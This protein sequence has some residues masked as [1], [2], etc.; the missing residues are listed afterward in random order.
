MTFNSNPLDGFKIDPNSISYV[1]TNIQRPECILAARDGSLWVT[2]PRGGVLKIGL[3]GSQTLIAPKAHDENTAHIDPVDWQNRYRVLDAVDNDGTSGSKSRGKGAAGGSLPNGIA[4]AP[5]G[6]IY[7][8]NVG[9]GRLE[10]LTRSGE[11]TVLLD[12][13]DGQ[14]IGQLNFV[15][16]D[17]KDRLWLTIPTREKEVSKCLRPDFTGGRIALYE[18]GKARIVA[19]GIHYTNEIRFDSKEE[20]LYISET[21]G[22]CVSRMRV[23][24]NGDLRNYQVFGPRDHGALIDGITFDSYGNLWG[25][26]VFTDQIFIITPEGDLR[27]L[28]DDAPP[29]QSKKLMEAF[30]KGNVT[31][32]IM[33]GCR[34][35]ISPWMTSITF[36]GA[37]LKTVYVGSI[38]GTAI[39]TFQS[40]VSG[41]PLPHWK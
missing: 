35:T 1:G 39:A 38:F 26:H 23:M 24:P 7:I 3:D 28:L 41:L 17:S 30:Y 15:L 22:P 18:N 31:R 10:R 21:C 25:T 12:S 36:G 34:G 4:F 32:E 16:A 33:M 9:L 6:D 14:E 27:I 11:L 8:A 29:A 37:A 13:I 40:P 19:E 5:N 2:D 20:W